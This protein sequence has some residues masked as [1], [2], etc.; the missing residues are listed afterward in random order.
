[1]KKK[2]VYQC[3]NCGYISQGFFGKCPNCNSWNT[4]EEKEEEPGK[5]APSK[6]NKD[7]LK[8]KSVEVSSDERV[9]TSIEEFNRVMGGGIVRDSVSILTAKPGSGKST[10]LMQVANDLANKGMRVLY[11]SGEESETQIKMRAER[12]LDKLSEN[13]WVYS[14]NSLNSVLDQVEKIDPQFIIIDSIQTFTLDEFPQR[15][16][17]PTQTMECAYKMTE[18]AKDINKPRMIFLVGQMT[19]QDELAG[20]RSL[21]HLVDTVLLIEGDSSEDLRSLMA[22]KNRY[23][24]TGEIG[25]FS[26]TEKGMISIDNPSEYFMTRRS[27]NEQVAGSS[28]SVIREGTRPI[29]LETEA[30]ASKTFLPYPSRISESIRREHLNTLVSILEERAGIKFLDKNIVVKS[31]GGIKVKEQASNLSVMVSIVSSTLNKPVEANSVFIADVGL[32]GEL[33]NV[34]SLDVRLKEAERMGFKK[35][36]VSKYSNVKEENY[37]NLQVIKMTNILEVLQKIFSI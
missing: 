17:T 32:T 20:V 18:I 35:A 28:L 13:I 16:G 27:E 31:A 11:A 21:E 8:L 30:L 6:N 33:K 36:Y 29:I 9:K 19:K 37:K 23:G 1:M 3:S 5:K 26:M 25:F 10:L 4:L 2:I 14:V 12:I 22:T 24:S 15:P 34:P 7:A